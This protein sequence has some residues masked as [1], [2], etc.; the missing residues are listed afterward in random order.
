MAEEVVDQTNDTAPAEPESTPTNVPAQE[1]PPDIPTWAAD[2]QSPVPQPQQPQYVPQ[3]QAQQYPQYAYPQVPQIQQPY[4]PQP[5]NYP[6]PAPPQPQYYPPPQ[7]YHPPQPPPSNPADFINTFAEHPEQMF[8]QAVN[9]R[10]SPFVE[11]VQAIDA[12]ARRQYEQTVQQ[13]EVSA[14]GAIAQAY[15]ETFSKDPAFANPQVRQT[16]ERSLL[17]YLNEARNDAFTKGDLSRYDN[18]SNPKFMTMALMASRVHEGWGDNTGPLKAPGAFTESSRSAPASSTKQE[19]IDDDTREVLKLMG[20][21]NE[22][23]IQE[24]ARK[25]RNMS[26]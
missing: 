2:P 15:K 3:P 5:Q 18:L 1:K 8:D 20:Y 14:R 7:P 16:L 19:D 12:L 4:Y 11:R 17:S 26:R 13:K 10:I 22:S 21:T 23:E 25:F 6:P 9:Q 24:R